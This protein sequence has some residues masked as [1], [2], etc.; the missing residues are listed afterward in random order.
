MAIKQLWFDKYRPKT[1][2]EYIFQDEQQKS[3]IHQMV[4]AGEVPHLMLTGVQGSGKTALTKILI[5]ALGVDEMDLMEVDASK[6]NSVEFVRDELIPFCETL[7]M[8]KLKIIHLAEF[9]YMSQ[10]AQGTLRETLGGD[11]STFRFIATCNYE[12]RIIP[13]LRSRFQVMRFKALNEDEI[14][15]QLANMLISEGVDVDPDVVLTYIKQAY[16]DVRQMINNIEFN[17]V[18]GVLRA[19][20][21]GA[22]GAD[23]K[24]KVLEL[25]GQGDF[26]AIYEL[27]L[28]QV[29]AEDIE[30]VYE[31][32]WQNLNLI[33]QCKASK[34]V[35]RK[36]VLLIADALRAHAVAAFPHVTFQALC[37]RI[38]MAIS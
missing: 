32:L 17:V 29:A 3:K 21:A 15:I 7:P 33:P 12:N 28:K 4:A 23:Y 22:A 34:D 35:Y 36:V 24:F 26:E 27:I 14:F 19:P 8:G 38:I 1:L 11:T 5:D 25:L 20:N 16:P 10:A 9:D 31:F 6:K 37:I 30:G 13:A 18:N 2:D